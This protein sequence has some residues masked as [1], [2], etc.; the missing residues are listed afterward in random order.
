MVFEEGKAYLVDHIPF[1]IHNLIFVI[2]LNP[3]SKGFC[4]DL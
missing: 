4:K 2:M 1:L 3:S